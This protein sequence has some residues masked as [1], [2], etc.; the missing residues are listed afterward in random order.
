MTAALLV[1]TAIHALLHFMGVAKAFGLVELP[2][3]TQPLDR[4]MGV[5]WLAA[6]LTLAAAADLPA[7]TAPSKAGDGKA[8]AVA[9][10]PQTASLHLKL[11]N[12]YEEAQDHNKAMAQWRM[13][14]DLEPDHP[15]RMKLLNLI[16][17]Y[18][19]SKPRPAKPAGVPDAPKADKARIE[20]DQAMNIGLQAFRLKAGGDNWYRAEHLTVMLMTHNGR[21]AWS[22]SCSASP[23]AGGGGTALVDAQTG[24]VLSVHIPTGLR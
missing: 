23:I 18:R 9:E 16:E 1:L 2:E 17:K 14:L 4:G 13:V 22:V 10:S 12:A 7:Q 11:G 15:Q 3:L 6:G 8:A 24:D 5:L 19:S 21:P 20:R